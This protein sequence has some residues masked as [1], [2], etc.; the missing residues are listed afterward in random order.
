M[1]GEQIS[2]SSERNNERSKRPHLA[3]PHRTRQDREIDDLDGL[4]RISTWL[5]QDAVLKVSRRIYKTWRRL[6]VGSI[7]W[8]EGR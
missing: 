3:N 4:G 1:R 5:A 6:F 2:H 7:N 8:R